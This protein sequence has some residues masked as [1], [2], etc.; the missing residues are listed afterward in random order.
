MKATELESKRFDKALDEIID[1]FNNI[2]SDEPI[3]RFSD[4]VINNIE[5]A[6]KKY[7]D[8][9]VNEKINTVVHEMLSWLDLSDVDLNEPEEEID[10]EDTES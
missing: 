4:E 5:L 6:K 7:G 3:I 10:E 8:S 9:V 2:E 1:L